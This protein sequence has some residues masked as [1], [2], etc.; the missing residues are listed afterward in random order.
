[1]FLT[2]AVGLISTPTH[3]AG[4]VYVLLSD[5]LIHLQNK[6]ITVFEMVNEVVA[7]KEDQPFRAYQPTILLLSSQSL[8]PL[9]LAY[10]VISS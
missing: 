5:K 3:R 2:D 7:L 9:N 10:P 4:N 1:M 6:L 8:L